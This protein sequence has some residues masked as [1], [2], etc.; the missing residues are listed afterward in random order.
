MIDKQLAHLQ[1]EQPGHAQRER[2]AG[3]IFVGFDGIDRLPRDAELAGNLVL[4][5]AGNIV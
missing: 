1:P 3:V 2:Q 4:G 5:V